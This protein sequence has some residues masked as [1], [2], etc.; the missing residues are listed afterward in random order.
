MNSHIVSTGFSSGHF[1]GN[2]SRVM[3]AGTTTWSDICHPA[4][5]STNMACAPG[6]T[7]AEISA[8]CRFIATIVATRHDQGCTLA[9]LRTNGAEDI[10]RGGPLIAE[11]HRS[12]AALGPAPGD[13]GL[14][15][16]AR[17]VLKPHFY[18]L[19]GSLVMRNLF[20]TREE[21]FLKASRAAGSWA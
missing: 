6:V 11:R 18:R 21:V 20:H 1:G 17:F 16:D 2:G 4:W 13:L 14:L 15:S 5:S 9:V 12:R 3:F 19:A 7:A 8:K 10:G